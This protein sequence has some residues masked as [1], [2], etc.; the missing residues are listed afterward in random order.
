MLRVVVSYTRRVDRDRRLICKATLA[1]GAASLLPACGNAS[2]TPVAMC[3]NSSL[4]VGN[5][6]DVP[7]NGAVN[8]PTGAAKADVDLPLPRR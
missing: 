3:G 4:G 7:L 2:S 5:A 1:L 6:A 8:I